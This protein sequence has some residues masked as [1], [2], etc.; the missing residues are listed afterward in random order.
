MKK[1]VAMLSLLALVLGSPAQGCDEQCKKEN[2]ERTTGEKFHSYLSWKFCEDTRMDFIT[3][4]MRSLDTYRSKHFDTRYKGGMRNIKNYVEQRKE[5]LIECDNYL[6]LTKKERVFDD[7]KTTK[8]IF[9]AMDDV[10]HELDDLIAG[11]TY[12]S[13]LGQDSAEVINEK[14]DVLLKRVD[15][16]KTLMH[17]KG[18]YVT[19]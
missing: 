5:W 1:L 14:F 19:R 13:S 8:A 3:S 2:A 17:L 7:E 11:V 15:D 9:K 4:S 16:H 12:S 18:R 10:T 6:Q